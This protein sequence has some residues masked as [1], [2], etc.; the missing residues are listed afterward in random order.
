MLYWQKV[1]KL[2][3]SLF[4]ST[5]KQTLITEK[6]KKKEFDLISSL[7]HIGFYGNGYAYKLSVWGKIGWRRTN[8]W[9]LASIYAPQKVGQACIIEWFLF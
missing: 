2:V 9:W 3:V 8:E 7:C 4:S 1:K 5:L 6:K